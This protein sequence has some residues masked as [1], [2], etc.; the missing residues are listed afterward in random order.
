MSSFRKLS[1]GSTAATFL[2]ISIGGLVR[3]TKSGLGCGTDWPHCAG[4]L[5]PALETRAEIIEFSHRA[6]ASV[7]VFLLGALV[8]VAIRNH[9]HSPR[10]LWPAV[11]AF[12]LVLWQAVLGMIVVKLELQAESVVLH[13]GTA[14]LL[15]GLLVYLS[16]ASKAAE[17]SPLPTDQEVSRAGTLAAAATFG[18]LLVGSFVSGKEAGLVFDDWPLMNGR[19]VPDLGME[20]QALHFVHRALAAIVG[21]IVLWFGIRVIRR[22]AT[23][24]IAARFAHVALGLFAVEILIGAM[25][26][27]TELNSVVVT[28]HLAT[29]AA[30]WA[31]FV[32]TAV[33]A[34]PVM[35]RV[36]DESPRRQALTAGARG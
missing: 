1:L 15:L 23:T 6:M 35:A 24:P 27:W 32:A 21:I 13:L 4:R 30:I 12:G 22:K 8:V 2:L 10:L 29:G 34:H 28:L 5:V 17:D 31:S 25:N 18:L 20:L 9:R 26:V 36:T 19:L 7:V 16:L 11:A 14:L 3:A 33:V